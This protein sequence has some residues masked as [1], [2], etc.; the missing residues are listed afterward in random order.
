MGHKLTILLG[1]LLRTELWHWLFDVV[2]ANYLRDI[3]SSSPSLSPSSPF[4]T[5]GHALSHG[6]ETTFARKTTSNR[7]LM[8]E[9]GGKRGRR[10]GGGRDRSCDLV[11]SS[12]FREIPFS[13]KIQLSIYLPSYFAS[14]HGPHKPACLPASACAHQP[15]RGLAHKFPTG[16][17]FVQVEIN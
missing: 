6:I 10:E 2:H 14:R 7:E 13:H 3:L 12:I 5:D 1:V 8:H 11:L 9:Q 15:A 17:P 16:K 4:E